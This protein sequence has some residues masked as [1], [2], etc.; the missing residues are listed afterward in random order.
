MRESV[1]RLLCYNRHKLISTGD[2][3]HEKRIVR[4]T[5]SVR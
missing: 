3:S 1:K 5:Q 4:I 2:S